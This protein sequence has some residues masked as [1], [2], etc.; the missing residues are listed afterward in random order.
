MLAA[1]KGF[2][3]VLPDYSAQS[4]FGASKK[5]ETSMS[6]IQSW[7]QMKMQNKCKINKIS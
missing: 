5:S 7:L 6:L 4:L 3:L 1:V 2:P